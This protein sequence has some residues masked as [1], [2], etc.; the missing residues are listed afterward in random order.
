VYGS[1]GAS[2]QISPFENENDALH[3][4][5]LNILFEYSV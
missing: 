4:F 1:I 5:E 3:E 2:T